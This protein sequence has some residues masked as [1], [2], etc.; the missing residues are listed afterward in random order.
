MEITDVGGLLAVLQAL[1]LPAVYLS[2]AV[3]ICAG[4]AMVLPKQLGNPAAQ[5]VYAPFRWLLDTLGGNRLNASNAPHPVPL[6]APVAAPPRPPVGTTPRLW[7]LV[8]L[9]PLL[10]CGSV[11]RLPA[12]TGITAAEAT[13]AAE[14]V[15]GLAL[16]AMSRSDLSLGTRHAIAVADAALQGAVAAWTRS[17]DADAARE[18]TVTLGALNGALVAAGVA[19]V[20]S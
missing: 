8:L 10:G 11:P 17:P 4:L 19:Q 12:A 16:A 9:L 6:A 15:H 14:M 13:I 3:S 7:L 5:R 18:M 2:A 20:A 1:G